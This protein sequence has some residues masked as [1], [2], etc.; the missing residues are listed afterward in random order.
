IGSN[1]SVIRV[2]CQCQLAYL[3]SL[4]W[5][6]PRLR[7]QLTT[8]KFTLEIFCSSYLTMI[9]AVIS[10]V[11]LLALSATEASVPY[12]R[13]TLN[14][15]LGDVIGEKKP[16]GDG[17]SMVE[18][19]YG[20]PYAKPPVGERRFREP[21]PAE[22][23]GSAP[24]DGTMKPYACWQSVDVAFD[25][26]PG[27]EMWNANT[28]RSED[29]LY[30]NVWRPDTG[31]EAYTAGSGDGEETRSG[32]A[33]KGIMVWIFGGSFNSGSATL[34]VYEA[35]QLAV[36]K[37]VIVVTMGYRVGALGFLYLGN[38]AVPGNAGLMDQAMALKWV[39]DNAANLGGHPDDITI[40][41]E[42]AG[43]ASVGL[44]LM[45]PL[46]KHLFKNAIMQSTS[47]LAYWAVMDSAKAKSRAL[48]LSSKVSCLDDSTSTNI[49][50][51]AL[52]SCL[53]AADPEN[54]TNEQWN[55]DGLSWFDVTFG[56]VVDGT[57]LISHPTTLMRN[58]DIKLTN[59]ILGVNKDEGIYFDIYAFQELGNLDR[60]GQL[61]S[62]EFDNIMLKIAKNN[63]TLKSEVIDL[64]ASYENNSYLD[65]VDAA[66]GDYL[67]K[68]S[69][70]DFAQEYTKLGGTVYLYSF[71]ENFSSNP[72]PDWM[73][74]PHGYEIELVFG[75]P[76]KDGSNN[77]QAEKNLTADVMSLWTNFAKTGSPTSPGDRHSWPVY[78]PGEGA[79]A[80][81]DSQGL[82]SGQ[83]FR[84]DQC[85]FWARQATTG[86][87]YSVPGSTQATE[88]L[89]ANA[90]Q[91]LNEDRIASIGQNQTNATQTLN[92]DRIASVGQNHSPSEADSSQ[93]DH[94]ME[95]SMIV[96]VP[97][98]DS[99]WPR[100]GG[101]ILP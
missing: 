69:V 35:S 97:P 40:F 64:Y 84:Q 93:N 36:R 25:R 77:T 51:E 60:N 56:P 10:W 80:I 95:Q 17:L 16:A 21:L 63:K 52:L 89:T 85:E 34:D 92:A 9:G 30:I 32:N 96:E 82:H 71:E 23:W 61:N 58:G 68:C 3:A 13:V 46:S 70:V 78:T 43:A 62:T 72:W 47:P 14:T 83:K 31:A 38:G 18:V 44:H 6:R 29:C 4:S 1:P 87:P 98:Q 55:I 19:Y 5:Q 99:S 54:I 27:V 41:G 66:S 22:H 28:N 57:F 2:F 37:D 49:D 33:H 101:N 65:I 45:S 81:I 24:L 53:Q 94:L 100:Q 15:N 48:D 75:I 79:Y 74:V 12:N 67:F 88:P 90:T 8:P 39:K 20:I 91:T 11:L 86:A 50:E 73:G 26:F 59:V 42:S 76:L 7:I